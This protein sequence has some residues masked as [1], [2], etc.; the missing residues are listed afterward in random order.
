MESFDF[1]IF[2][3]EKFQPCNGGDVTM[4]TNQE[5]EGM[6]SGEENCER[7]QRQGQ[8]QG[9]G[10]RH[11]QRRY[12]EPE[13]LEEKT[14]EQMLDKIPVGWFHYRLL[15]ICGLAFMA[16]GMVTQVCSII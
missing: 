9:H 3:T 15:L 12:G 4:H 14:L 10:N 6:R 11:G 13:P 7:E 5:V 1:S 16:D 2:S 8:G